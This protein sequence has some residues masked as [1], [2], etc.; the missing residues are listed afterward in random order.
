[1]SGYP[2]SYSI[3]CP[4]YG[5]GSSAA[6]TPRPRAGFDAARTTDENKKHWANADSLAPVSQLT[7]QIRALLR[8]RARYECLNNS[9][10]AG[11]VRTLV[12]DT[13]G[14]GPRLQM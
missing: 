8:N 7:P 5:G 14:K 13:V 9:F 4:V 1:M 12:N 10:A 6:P 2:G 3:S 11:A